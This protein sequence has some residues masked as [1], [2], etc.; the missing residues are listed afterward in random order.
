MGNVLTYLGLFRWPNLLILALT[1]CLFRYAVIIPAIENTGPRPGVSHSLFILLVLSTTGIAAAGYA[2]NDYFDLRIDRINKPGKIILGRKLG[3]RHA[4]VA[5]KLL[6][7]ISVSMGL[8]VSI[9]L[10]SWVLAFIFLGSPALLWI[11]SI[12]LKRQFLIGNLVV[13]LLSALPVVLVWLAEYQGLGR[14]V[15][16][17][18]ALWTEMTRMVLFYGL[19]AF[20]LTAIR[21]ILK[22]L[23]DVKGDRCAGCRTLPVVLGQKGAKTTIAS[24]L[25]LL[26]L[27]LAAFQL[28]FFRSGNMGMVVFLLL[29]VQLPA[30]AIIPAL[31][32]ED[33]AK[34]FGSLQRLTKLIM[35]AGVLSM[36]FY[37]QNVDL[38][39]GFF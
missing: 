25:L 33:R 31:W 32:K 27:C 17:P 30:L 11:Y 19:L 2:I 1:Q 37:Q 7:L 13:A 10:N 36:L 23:E 29:L 38:H 24:L 35:A 9:R 28:A 39:Y 21:E 14:T 16:L 5:H 26:I 12:R 4:I 6:N 20:L 8:Y 34:G 3:R 15:E 22:D 18:P